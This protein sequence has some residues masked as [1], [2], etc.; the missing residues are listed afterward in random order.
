V[1]ADPDFS[2]EHVDHC[3]RC[4]GIASLARVGEPCT[5]CGKEL[6]LQSYAGTEP[7]MCLGCLS[8]FR[9]PQK[10]PGGV[11]SADSPKAPGEAT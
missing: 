4:R 9:W 6:T 3:P 8:S 11:G 2:P 7:G 10:P 1:S 5:V